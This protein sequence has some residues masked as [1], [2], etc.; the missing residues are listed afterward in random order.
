MATAY[1][2]RSFGAS[3]FYPPA[4]ASYQLGVSE[5]AVG[6]AAAITRTYALGDTVGIVRLAFNEKIVGA[7]FSNDQLDSNGSPLLAGVL[8]IVDPDGSTITLITL[9]GAILGA[10]GGSITGITNPAALGYVVKTRSQTGP[11]YVQFRVTAAPATGVAGSIAA[12]VEATNT[13]YGKEDMTVPT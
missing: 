11:A 3:P 7:R 1:Y 2:A 9:T 13:L 4:G 10:A 12:F 6:N 5:R 8:E